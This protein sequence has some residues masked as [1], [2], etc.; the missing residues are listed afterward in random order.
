[1]FIS[2]NIFKFCGE[3]F[4]TFKPKSKKTQ[5]CIPF[6]F[7]ILLLLDWSLIQKLNE[8]VHGNLC[9]IMSPVS[10]WTSF[11]LQILYGCTTFTTLAIHKKHI[12]FF[13]HLIIYKKYQAKI[14]SIIGDQ[15]ISYGYSFLKKKQSN[16]MDMIS[17]C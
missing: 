7:I 12:N 13:T 11:C 17:C 4:E 16:W 15:T 1:M 2:S 14:K 3:R 5:T 6:N 10:I 9:K 8:P